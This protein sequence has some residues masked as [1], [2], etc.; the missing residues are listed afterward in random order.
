[1]SQRTEDIIRRYREA[2][3]R[4]LDEI[5]K[6]PRGSAREYAQKLRARVAAILDGLYTANE[7]WSA[8]AIPTMYANGR[9][10]VYNAV[11]K[12][13]QDNDREPPELPETSVEEE[14][15]V[16]SK[17]SQYVADTGHAITETRQRLDRIITG[18]FAAAVLTGGIYARQT[19][20]VRDAVQDEVAQNRMLLADYAQTAAES[21]EHDMYNTSAIH[22]SRELSS[23][24]VHVSEHWGSCPLCAPYQ[25]LVYSTD[26]SNPHY[27][28]LYDTPYS[29]AYGN[30][31]PRCRH[32]VTLYIEALQSPEEV[33]AMQKKSSRST[34]IGGEGWTKAETERA[35]RSLEAYR[36]RQTRNRRVYDDRKQYARY[37][38]VLGDKAPKSFAG[39]RR[40]KLA[41]G[42]AWEKLQ[43]EYRKYSHATGLQRQLPFEYNG[44][45]AYIPKDTVITNVKAIAGSDKVREIDDIARIS[46]TY[47]GTAEGWAKKVGKIESDRYVFDIHWYERDGVQYE[48]KIKYMK[49]KNK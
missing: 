28:Y 29:E 4:I 30:F 13:Y 34:E 5:N 22:L 21:I 42:K 25:G 33:A 12:E 10:K 37:K 41:D 45:I 23:G 8:Q 39:F 48:S 17:R 27:P 9:Q 2:E 44:N 26:P 38:T 6:Q 32:V 20:V 40:S 14:I 3:Q 49:E 18:A 7:R 11:R 15:D 19:R 47:G 1:M 24:L 35:K 36:S 16:E 43:A 46:S 31:H